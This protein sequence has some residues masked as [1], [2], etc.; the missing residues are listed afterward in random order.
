MVIVKFNIYYVSRG[1]L[2]W[3]INQ[4]SIYENLAFD[5]SWAIF[6]KKMWIDCPSHFLGIKVNNT[7][8]SRLLISIRTT[9]K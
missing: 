2:L 7:F 9:M 1:L 5:V 6:V 8:K 3:S 4:I